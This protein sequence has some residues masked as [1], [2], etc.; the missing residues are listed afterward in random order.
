MSG[1]VTGAVTAGAAAAAAAR[2][3]H[4]EEEDMTD[5]KTNDLDGWEF[6]IIRT[7]TAKFKN[8]ETIQKLCQEEAKAGW[9]ML[10][11]FDDYRI[12]F[13]RRVDKRSGDRYLETDPYRTHLGMGQGKMVIGI[14]AATFLLV[15]IFVLIVI[16]SR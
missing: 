5:Y 6:K 7:N 10:E 11:K 15:G 13:K 14:L 2:R 3:M 8:F 16:S 1:A 4:Q 9:E 12:R